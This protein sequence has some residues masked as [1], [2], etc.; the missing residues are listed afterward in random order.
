MNVFRRH[1][2]CAPSH[3]AFSYLLLQPGCGL[4]LN[5]LMCCISVIFI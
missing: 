4:S 2:L 5:N 1:A 3:K